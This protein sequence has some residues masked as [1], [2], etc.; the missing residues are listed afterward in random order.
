MTKINISLFFQLVA[1]ILPLIILTQKRTFN[2][3]FT[4]YLILSVFTTVVLFITTYLKINNL[5]IA[6]FYVLLSFISIII[7]FN[8]Y[9]TLNN[10]LLIYIFSSIF[11]LVFIYEMLN[12]SFVKNAIS[13]FSLSSIV[14]SLVFMYNSLT[15]DIS[16]IKNIDTHILISISLLF[17]NSVSFVMYLK[18]FYFMK[19]DIWY[20]HNYV[21]GISKLI[22]TYAFWKLPKISQSTN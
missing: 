19:N 7:Y 11:S 14:L 17:Y 9:N 16:Q 1:G 20:I 18:M 2:K 6:N 10:R 15:K 5:L 21:E 22:I 4:F 8:N 13:I 3:S 12:F